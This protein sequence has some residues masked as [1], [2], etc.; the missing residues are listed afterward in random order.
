MKLNHILKRPIFTEKSLRLAR[1]GWYTF[2][3]DK[4]ATKKDIAEACKKLFKV[5][6]LAVKTMIVKGKTRRVGRYRQEVKKAS[7]KKAMIKI[8]KDKKIDLFEI[9]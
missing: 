4:K 7:W 9:T 1:Q 6:P 3:V 2:E 5:E 8:E